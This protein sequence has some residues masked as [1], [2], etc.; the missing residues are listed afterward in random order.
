[1]KK[2]K[3]GTKLVGGVAIISILNIIIG[4]VGLVNVYDI[5]NTNIRTFEGQ[6]SA[7]CPYLRV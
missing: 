6:Y 3:L 1:M 5:N 4:I 7:L 2:L